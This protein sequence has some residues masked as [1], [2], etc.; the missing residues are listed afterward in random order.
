MQLIRPSELQ[1]ALARKGIAQVGSKRQKLKGTGKGSKGMVLDPQQ[2]RVPVGAFV[3][4]QGDALAQVDLAHLGSKSVGVAVVSYQAAKPFLKTG[5]VLSAGALALLVVD[6]PAGGDEE[7]ERIRVPL[8]CAANAEPVLVDSMLFQVGAVQVRRAQGDPNIAVKSIDS[9]VT[10]FL[11]FRDQTPQPWEEVCSRPIQH[12]LDRVPPLR[13]CADSECTGCEEWHPASKCPVANP[14]L[15]VWGRQWL[16]T[17]FATAQPAS[18]ELFVVQ[19]RTPACLQVQLQSYSGIQGTYIEPKSIDGRSPSPDFQVVWV[20]RASLPD[21]K[22]QKQTL[23]QVI[24]L[25]RLG[26]KYGLRC[27]TCD[28]ASVLHRVKPGHVYL[29]AGA[30]RQYRV[31]PFPFGTLK[32]SVAAVLASIGWVARPTQPITAGHHVQGLMYRVQATASPPKQVIPMSHGDVV[33]TQLRQLNPSRC[34]LVPRWLPRPPHCRYVLALP[35]PLIS[36]RLM[37]LGPT[38]R[39]SNRRSSTL[40]IRWQTWSSAS[41]SALWLAC[42]RPTWR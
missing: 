24:G 36:S 2:L 4:A 25:A 8:L 39:S 32:E 29:P 6:P 31:G 19:M 14:V 7:G 10:K 21:V 42:H 16:T 33:I 38:R 20:P 17:A 34:N 13:P 3:D 26:Q 41:Q 5:S 11:V 12:I 18:A 30:K 23:P 35:L 1:A 9:C 22:V 28:A 40:V 15:E 27:R 37:T